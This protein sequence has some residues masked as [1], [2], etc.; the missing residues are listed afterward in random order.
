MYVPKRRR[1]SPA[2]PISITL[3]ETQ[4]THV[5]KYLA[6]AEA[7]FHPLEDSASFKIL[8]EHMVPSQGKFAVQFE[9]LTFML[10]CTFGK[11]TWIRNGDEPNVTICTTSALADAIR[12][13][14]VEPACRFHGVY[15]KEKQGVR[16]YYNK[17]DDDWSMLSS[18]APTQDLSC[19][20]L[21][22]EI[23]GDILRHL[24]EWKGQ[25]TR[26]LRYGR[27][28]KTGMMLVGRPGMGKTTLVRSI[29]KHLNRSL[30]VLNLTRIK[31][32]NLE[33]VIS[34]IA[35]GSILVV[36]DIDSLYTGKDPKDGSGCQIPYSMFLN[37][38]DGNMVMPHGTIVILT[39]N[40]LRSLDA[41]T[42]LRSGR[43]DRMFRF[44]DVTRSQYERAF[45]AI[46]ESEEV[47]ADLWKI[48]ER[49]KLPMSAVVDILFHKSTSVDRCALAREK[50]DTF[51]SAFEHMYV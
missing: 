34:T 20:F 23:E 41:P 37:V 49:R 50:H 10:E 13:Q 9:E 25:E 6:Q 8:D 39:A 40:D 32:Q 46:T 5:L 38:L 28:F 21:P 48:I 19:M 44:G 47:D 18:S 2:V 4:S 42:L 24:D 14:V 33:G 22:D 7:T 11:A 51:E 15:V 3:G 36:D 16:V 27:M 17:Y 35:P 30:Y 31:P 12:E 43:V 29:A 1:T 45:R 26:Y